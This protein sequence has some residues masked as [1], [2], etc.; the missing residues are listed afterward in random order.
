MRLLLTGSTGF[1][2]RNLLLRLLQA[3]KYD[4]IWLPVRS[5]EKLREQLV[6]EGY[7]DLPSSVKVVKTEAPDWDL[8]QIPSVEDV[9]HA[10]ATLSGTN[11]EEYFKVNKDGTRRLLEQ[12]PR[13]ARIL[14]LS[15]LAAAGPCPRGVQQ[16]EESHESFPVTWYGESKLAMEEMLA[17][18]FAD[19]PYLCL[20]PPMV[21]G[22]RD[23]ASLPLFKMAKQPLRF[24]P[25][26]RIKRYSYIAVGDLVSA[27]LSALKKDW[28]ALPQRIFFVGSDE[29]VTDADLINESARA[30]NKTGLTLSIPHP[31]IW[32]VSRV[33]DQVPAW[34][35]AIPNLSA[36]RAR[37]IWPQS[38]VA[39]AEPF[40]KNF[41][42]TPTQNFS[43][44]LKETGD[45]YR[46]S[47]QL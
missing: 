18:D 2:G 38:W 4:E 39:S 37:E 34:R 23:Q 9:V 6:G 22:P 45:W 28:S 33:V 24:K 32:G 44:L 42:W 25:G 3:K 16:R 8:S 15:S 21:L 26:F 13:S 12:L 41:D 36:D 10:A 27:I 1:V 5:P 20:R 43:D 40:K 7:L 17:K 30:L 14:I 11:R 19:R 35:K 29:P 31:I 46:A 47:R